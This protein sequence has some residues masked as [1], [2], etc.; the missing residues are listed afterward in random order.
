MIKEG[1]RK[2]YFWT[3]IHKG[4]YGILGNA[5]FIPMFG[6]KKQLLKYYNCQEIKDYKPT[7]IEIRLYEE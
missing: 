7:K 3:L 4:H 2:K 6:S 1:K 5:D